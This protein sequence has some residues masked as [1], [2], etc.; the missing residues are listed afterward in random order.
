MTI[1]SPRLVYDDMTAAIAEFYRQVRGGG[2]APETIPDWARPASMAEGYAAQDRLVEH[3]LGGS[4]GRPAGYKLACT[5][6]HTQVLLNTDGPVFARLLSTRIWKSGAKLPASEFPM[7]VVEA[8][9]AFDIAEDVPEA[10][11]EWTRASIAAFVGD[12]MPSLEL[13]GHRFGDWST[14]DAA[15]L[16][17]DN[18]VH[19]GLVYGAPTARW[20]DID[21][22]AQSV[23][24]F[25]D[26]VKCRSGTGRNVLGHPLNA[27]AWLARALPAHGLRLRKGDRVTTGVATEIYPT[28]PGE[29]VRAEFGDLGT[30][31]VM[32]TG[33][34]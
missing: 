14:Y 6:K 19:Q 26:G 22:A 31:E 33:A 11:T 5:N 3:L 23:E 12:M 17:A 1:D 29:R 9:F 4:G 15:S 20:R 7:H 18:A 30:V 2:P 10:D 25:A 13:V 21:L 8:E 24:V 28:R 27:I 32:F 34:G 16:A